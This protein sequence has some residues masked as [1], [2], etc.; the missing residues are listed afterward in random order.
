[1]YAPTLLKLAKLVL[2]F[3]DLLDERGR[4]DVAAALIEGPVDQSAVLVWVQLDLGG[5]GLVDAVLGDLD[6]E[7]ADLDL[8]LQQKSVLPSD[9]TAGAWRRWPWREA[10]GSQRQ[11][12]WPLSRDGHSR[13]S[14]GRWDPCLS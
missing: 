1:M 11:R 5:D 9:R 2:N 6:T 10:E 14:S 3:S 13:R 8:T 12:S 7:L 4:V